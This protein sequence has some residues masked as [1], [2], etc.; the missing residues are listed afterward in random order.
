MANEKPKILHLTLNREAFE[1]MVTGEKNTEYRKPT[2]WIK[3]RLYHKDGTKKS[4]DLVKFTNGYG[5]DR[6]S[7]TRE[8]DGFGISVTRHEKKFSN[9][10]K[11][12]IERGD[13]QILLKG[14]ISVENCEEFGF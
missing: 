4:F 13:F 3:S 6:P 2:R 5:K 10:L 8:F 7:F 1:V 11:V 12:T 14:K 9:G